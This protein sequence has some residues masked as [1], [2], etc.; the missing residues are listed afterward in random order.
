MNYPN[1][2]IYLSKEIPEDDLIS[3]EKSQ[4]CDVNQ[5]RWIYAAD[6]YGFGDYLM[7]KLLFKGP[8]TL[9]KTKT[10]CLSCGERTPVLAVEASGYVPTGGKGNDLALNIAFFLEGGID[11]LLEKPVYLTYVQ[12]YPP[13]FL[14][15]IRM[16]S[17]LFRKHNFGEDNDYFANACTLCKTPVDDFLLYY[18]QDGPLARCNPSPTRSGILLNYDL[19]IICEAQFG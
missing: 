10:K 7:P 8:F 11:D 3:L 15:L 13:E 4:W 16:S 14:K 6:V 5:K 12:E 2:K 9:F 18:E 19:P 17:F 1:M